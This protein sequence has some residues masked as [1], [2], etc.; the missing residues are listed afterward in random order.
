MSSRHLAFFYKKRHTSYGRHHTIRRAAWQRQWPPW[1]LR[2]RAVP[3][4]WSILGYLGEWGDAV[5]VATENIRVVRLLVLHEDST[6][7]PFGV[8]DLFIIG[9]LVNRGKVLILHFGP[10]VQKVGYEIPMPTL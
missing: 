3:Y 7:Y 10:A 5:S 9:N 2:V 1:D 8:T 4:L 6:R